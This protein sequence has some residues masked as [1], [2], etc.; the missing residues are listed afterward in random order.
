MERMN[1][2]KKIDGASHLNG[3]RTAENFIDE[4]VLRPGEP[5]VL[6]SLVR[7]FDNEDAL[8]G[9]CECLQRWMRSEFEKGNLHE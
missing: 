3:T 8:R 1:T 6:F 2:E 5:G 9:F 4:C 7:R